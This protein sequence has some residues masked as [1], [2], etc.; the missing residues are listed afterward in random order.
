VRRPDWFSGG[1]G[2]KG[3]WAVGKPG[4]STCCLL[5]E[6]SQRGYRLWGSKAK[7]PVVYKQK[8]SEGLRAVGK[9]G[10]SACCL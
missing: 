5:T 8:G 3:L 6:K 4:K 1:R 9:P 10:K 2:P 7:V